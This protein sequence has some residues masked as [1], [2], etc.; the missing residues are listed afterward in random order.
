MIN[1]W[2]EFGFFLALFAG[3]GFVSSGCLDAARQAAA[4][5]QAVDQAEAQVDRLCAELDSRTTDSG[6]YI[7]VEEGDI[8]ERDP[9]GKPLQVRYS[10]GGVAE[11]VTVRSA[12]PDRLWN[13]EDDLLAQRTSVNLKGIGSGIKQ[14]VQETAAEAAKGLVKGAIEGVKESFQDAI[15]RRKEKAPEK[16]APDDTG[17]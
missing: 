10:A 16:T 9:W 12:G 6:V 8:L 5:K 15:Q 13:T 4:Q 1:R 11:T 3:V 2:R 7:R 17:P 14:N